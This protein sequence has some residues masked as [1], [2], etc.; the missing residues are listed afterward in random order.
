MINLKKLGIDTLRGQTQFWSIVLVVLPSLLGLLLFGAY[1]REHIKCAKQQQ[2]VQTVALER[3]IIDEWL[4]EQMSDI[5][6]ISQTEVVRQ[7]DLG[8]MPYIL[9]VFADSHVEFYYLNYSNKD[10]AVMA[11]SLNI[12]ETER[13]IANCDF[14][15]N[16][17]AGETC[18]GEVF[19]D[20][21]SGEPMIALAIPVYDNTNAIQ[22]VLYGTIKTSS[23][24]KAIRQKSFARTG[25][26]YIV[27]QNGHMITES[28][29][30]KLQTMRGDIATAQLY[31][32]NNGFHNM[33]IGSSDAVIYT[34]YRGEKVLG[35]SQWIDR[36][37]CLMVAKIDEAEIL[38]PYYRQLTIMSS[39]I[40]LIVAAILPLTVAISR[41]IKKLLG[42]LLQGSQNF[43]AGKY[44]YT[45]DT[46]ALAEEP[47]EIIELCSTFNEM[48]QKLLEHHLELENRVWKRTAELAQVNAALRQEIAERKIA[49]NMA[50]ETRQEIINIL[51]SI[52]DGFYVLDK[53]CR[54]IYMNKAAEQLSGNLCDELVSQELL[55]KPSILLDGAFYYAYLKAR[56]EQIVVCAEGKSVVLDK[57]I[58]L[59]IYPQGEN[60][61]V[62]FRDISNRKQMEQEMERLGQLN[63]V[64][65][66]AAGI[67]HEVR[68]PMTTVRGFLQML[69]KKEDCKRYHEYFDIMIGEIDR[70]NAIIT[71]FLSLAKNK[72]IKL[73][74]NNLNKIIRN[75]A[76]LIEADGLLVNK[77]L[78]LDLGEIPDIQLDGN[79]IRQL[80]LN[81]AR[82][83]LEAMGH[84]GYLTIRTFV[85]NNKIVMAV[86]DQGSGIP[87]EMMDKV[88]TPF[89]TTKEQGT[90]LGLAVCYSIAARHQ[91]EIKVETG[92]SGTTFY[93]MF[94]L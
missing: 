44:G 9:K 11:S 36:M 39:G 60:L 77:Y 8:L 34:D 57:W 31:Q 12:D 49:E 26:I 42:Y 22:G 29:F 53:E 13:N 89:F 68:N 20:K 88:G 63:M 62:Y 28:R 33:Q 25:E 15:K 65:E 79:E 3:Q 55:D 73:E 7:H 64:G 91:A 37:N 40:L 66:M 19:T 87:P 16:A 47:R 45:I 69:R 84:G 46:A 83:G 70:A 76:P 41:R 71:E 93:V 38:E 74:V 92:L 27:D 6:S 94:N 90:G 56:D 35:I 80:I 82:N 86:K 21:L 1:E 4:D 18:I 78:E 43:A 50:K 24:T 2:L 51:E 5:E 30:V 48:G 81:L 58:E 75:L 14:F 54:V 61:V 17:I 72:A 67:G 59:N 23:I 10:G 85:A 52:S 32:Q